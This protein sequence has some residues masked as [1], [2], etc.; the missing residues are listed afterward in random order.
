M[1]ALPLM[2]SAVLLNLTGPRL[3]P[4]LGLPNALQNALMHQTQHT[5]SWPELPLSSIGPHETS[6]ERNG[7]HCPDLGWHCPD[8]SLHAQTRKKNQL[9]TQQ[10]QQ[11]LTG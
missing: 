9:R 11:W 3:M 5:T 2:S 7:W 6:Q 8:L 4:S 1:A 10:E